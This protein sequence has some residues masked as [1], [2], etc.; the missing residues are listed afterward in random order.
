MEDTWTFVDALTARLHGPMSFR[1]FLQP[2]VAI[3]FAVRDGMRDAREGRA[4]FLSGL[5]TD[6]GHRLER[7][8]SG[9]KGIG[10][11]F[12]V[13]VVLD[14]VFQCIVFHEL[15]ELGVL[16]A[17]VILAILPYLAFRGPVNRLLRRCA[18]AE[19]DNRS[20]RT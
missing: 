7:L 20:S 16:A 9:W 12:L 2:L 8:S 11:V 13:A 14:V 5:V 15:R 4:P 6:A 1:F 3:L 10:K 18:K 19:I 17:G